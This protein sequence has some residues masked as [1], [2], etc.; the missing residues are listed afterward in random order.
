MQPAQL[1]LI[2]SSKNSQQNLLKFAA[3]SWYHSNL[4]NDHPPNVNRI[5]IR[6]EALLL[7]LATVYHPVVRNI[8][9]WPMPIYS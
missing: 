4:V 1:F 7:R 6:K 9:H 8:V 2:I 5:R 3:L